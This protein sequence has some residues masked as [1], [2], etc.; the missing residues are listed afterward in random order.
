[1]THKKNL[2]NDEKKHSKESE[3]IKRFGC[4][5][6][7]EKRIIEFLYYVLRFDGVRKIL[8]C[9]NMA[10]KKAQAMKQKAEKRS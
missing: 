4:V 7:H 8:S 3:R 2:C 9:V 1:M 10:Q 6:R 5:C